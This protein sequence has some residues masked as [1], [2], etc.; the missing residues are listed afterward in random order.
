M[1][2]K[3]LLGKGA[4]PNAETTEGERPLDWAHVQGDRAKIEVLERT[5]PREV[6]DRVAKR[7]R[8]PPRGASPIH[9]SH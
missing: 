6:G 9:V 7:S 8:L 5:A 2:L 3:L 1:R 4:N